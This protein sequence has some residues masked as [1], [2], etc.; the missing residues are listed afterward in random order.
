MN[1]PETIHKKINPARRHSYHRPKNISHSNKNI[2]GRTRHPLQAKRPPLRNE[3]KRGSSIPPIEKYIIRII[4]FGG[5]EEVGKNMTAFEYGD[6]I[7]VVDAGIYFPGDETP[8]VDYVIPDTTYLEER[9]SKIRGLFITHAHLDH[10]GAIPYV[11]EKLGTPPIYARK[12]SA[13]FIQK[14]QSEFLHLPK[15]DMRI[16]EREEK[17]KVGSL[18][19][20]F[21]A[22]THT[23]P[24][25]MGLIIGTPHGNI[26]HSG[27][28]KIDHKDG[29]PLSFEVEEFTK[30]GNENN[31]CLLTD[32]TNVDRPGF[33]FPE[34]EVHEN[35]RKIIK[36]TKGRLIIGTFA[37]L[38]ERI[39]YIINTAEELGKKVVIDGRSMKVNIE[40]ARELELLKKGLKSIIP[41]TEMENHPPE[42]VIILA[43]GAQGDAYAVLMRVANK[44]HKYIKINN[45]DTIILSSSII[46]GN[47]RGVQ[48][49]KDN[50]SRQ[51]AKILHYA[52][53]DVHSSGHAYKDEAA[54]II[55]MLNPKFFIPIHG[56][57]YMLRV[58]KAIAES[59]GLSD[60]NIVI[61]DNGM[62]VEIDGQKQTIS[63]LKKRAP[64]GIVMVDALGQGNVK[65]VVVRDR[66]ALAT[67]GMFVIVAVIDIKTGKVRKSPD[68]ISRGFVYL[69]ESQD[70]LSQTRLLVK[71][72][73][74]NAVGEMHPI[75]F[76]YVKNSLR[77]TIG[78]FL[79]Q[80]TK[81]RPI[82]LPVILEV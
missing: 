2:I 49:L 1:E 61:P 10:I 14:R 27:D 65:D 55:K 41:I 63:Q 78:K 6:D 5:V 42:N 12:L 64:A 15:L 46:P 54:W 79:Y 16:V 56:Y 80:Q 37:S 9:K 74:E 50:L 43:T 75:N 73:T 30:I 26:I 8:G 32:S 72:T 33:G 59:Q 70:L 4:P 48:K 3:E 11:Q 20:S 21:F 82:I 77:E 39:I 51:G 36:E 31:L 29:E 68:I 71:K 66:K 67:D 24:E 62:V 13:A 44:Q 47:E 57:H 7:I 17:I 81:K 25:A 76:D 35:L 34:R 45:H 19:V 23:I 18:T 69:K 58:H 53:A 38:L 52:I 22:V 40:I 28:L 60:K